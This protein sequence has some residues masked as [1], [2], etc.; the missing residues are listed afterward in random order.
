MRTPLGIEGFDYHI[1]ADIAVEVGDLVTVPFRRGNLIGIVAEIRAT[2]AFASRALPL[3]GHYANLHLPSALIDLI[4]ATAA[5]TF[6]SKPAVLK[7][8]LRS[9]PKKPPT[10]TLLPRQTKEHGLQADWQAG[11]GEELIHRAQEYQQKKRVLIV[12]PWMTRAELLHANIPGSHLLHSDISDGDAFRAWTG[13]LSQSTGCLVTSKIG[14]WLAVASDVVLLDEPEQDDHKQDDLA[15]RYDARKV[16]LFCAQQGMTRIESLGLTPPLHAQTPPP[17]IEHKPRLHIH[18]PQGKSPI[19]LIQADSFTALT[20]H[21]GPRIII[22]AI[23]GSLARLTCRDCQWQATCPICTGGLGAD[24]KGAICRRC[25]KHFPMPDQCGT[26]GGVD[27]SK[28]LPGI[29]RLDAIWQKSCPET[30]VEWRDTTAKELEKPF[31]LGCLVVVTEASLL[32][33]GED[34]RRRERQCI[35]IRRLADRVQQA[36]GELI[37]QCREDLAGQIQGW[38]TQTGMQAFVEQE[39]QERQTFLYPPAARIVKVVIKGSEE[40]A[41]KWLKQA[42]TWLKNTSLRTGEWRGP[43][44][45]EYQPASRGIRHILHLI[46]PPQTSEAELL[47]ALTPCAQNAIIDLDPIAFL[48]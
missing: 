23:R 30:T 2:S 24:S 47:S 20:E 31:P 15:P 7:S 3:K 11:A 48:R 28:S 22:H 46:L 32:G 43:F 36:N 13:F 25:H 34:I 38:M 16:L 45:P 14:A 4:Q 39:R 40:T 27:L 17:E 5:R 44:A 29:E 41:N 9:L 8:W 33:G 37:L 1:P 26:C 19:P 21:E 12:T 6:S 18:H 10:L 42:Q 35:A